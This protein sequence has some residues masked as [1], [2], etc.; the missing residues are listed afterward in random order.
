MIVR[1]REN[2]V[3]YGWVGFDAF[4]GS[5]P[6]LLRAV[7]DSGD[8]FVADVRSN[9]HFYLEDP[10][11]YR[12]RR[13][14]GGGR[15]P[16]ALRARTEACEMGDFFTGADAAEWHRVEI[17]EADKGVIRVDACARRVWF[18]DGQEKQARCWWAVCV[19]DETSG[20]TKFFV[21]NAAAD[22][23]L[24]ELVR[25]HAV[26][27]WIER[28]FQDAKTSLGMADYQARGWPAWHHHMAMIM[29]AMLF[30][31]R[32]RRIHLV[33]I[34]LLSCQDIVELLNVLL[35]RRDA[36]PEAVIRQMEIRHR[37]RKASILSARRSSLRR[38]RERLAAEPGNLSV[39][40]M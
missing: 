10:A 19:I 15:S 37:K 29:L 4:Y 25:K 1:A 5:V 22:T 12:P 11:P 38:Y 26:R 13:R 3:Q 33:K 18:W 31:L 23:P 30:L 28:G 34:E 6:W 32:E 35:P 14:S 40:T 8:I 20:D 16:Q 24:E 21:S 7:A 9:A 27:F 17:R 36:S 39:L 2:G